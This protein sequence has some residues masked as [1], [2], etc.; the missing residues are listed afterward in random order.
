MQSIKSILLLVHKVP[1]NIMCKRSLS[2]LYEYWQHHSVTA[3]FEKN[4]MNGTCEPNLAKWFVNSVRF[5]YL[6]LVQEVKSL[7]HHKL[8][9]L[10]KQEIYLPN[11][12]EQKFF[13]K[14]PQLLTWHKHSPSTMGPILACL[15]TLSSAIWIGPTPSHSISWGL[16]IILPSH[17]GTYKI[18]GICGELSQQPALTEVMMKINHICLLNFLVFG[19]VI[20]IPL[21]A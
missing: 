15:S 6:K 5:W 18:L 8:F 11:S 7:L 3:C 16:I 4:W 14:N 12:T 1:Q 20:E 19:S 9:M 2:S 13:L 17:L 21:N 10:F